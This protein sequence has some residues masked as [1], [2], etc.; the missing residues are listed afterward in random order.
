MTEGFDSAGY[1]GDAEDARFYFVGGNLSLDL[2]NTAAAVRGRPVE[3]LQDGADLSAWW[4]EASGHYPEAAL[5]AFSPSLLH[6]DS[7]LEEVK[8]LRASLRRIF[9]S[10]AAARAIPEADL[11]VLNASLNSG[12]EVIELGAAGQPR[13]IVRNA[14]DD[15]AGALLP[16]A[17]AAAALLA[18]EEHA[19]LHRCANG[20]CVLLFLDATKSGTRRWCSTGCMHRWRSS[21]RYRKRKS[22]E[23]L[24]AATPSS[25]QVHRP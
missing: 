9:E 24:G 4:R 23:S 18:T 3:L 15:V 5:P 22:E 8:R 13:L 20:R 14:G 12:R 19:R 1:E 17:R 2:I 21:D 7:L 10:V 11:S 25:P 6:D 16:L